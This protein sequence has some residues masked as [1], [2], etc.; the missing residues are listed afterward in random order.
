[1]KRSGK[2]AA[3]GLE[4][5]AGGIPHRLSEIAGCRLAPPPEADIPVPAG[6]AVVMPDGDSAIVRNLG[7]LPLF[8][9]P[10]VV[11][12]GASDRL[13]VGEVLHLGEVAVLLRTV[14]RPPSRWPLF[15]VVILV[16][17]ACT[18]WIAT[19]QPTPVE[20]PFE[21]TA[22]LTAKYPATL[23]LIRRARQAQAWGDSALAG[24]FYAEV[25]DAVLARVTRTGMDA[26]DRLILDELSVRRKGR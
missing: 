16:F 7:G 25:R 26:D 6:S 12:Q 2:K 15:A 11:P 23:G 14:P 20:R 9:G 17:A 5:V 10:R 8:C 1:M 18:W 13:A 22:A 24:R 3:A 4:L 21:L 19:R